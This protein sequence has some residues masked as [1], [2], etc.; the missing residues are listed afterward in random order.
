MEVDTWTVHMV[1]VDLRKQQS[2]APSSNGKGKGAGGPSIAQARQLNKQLA[3]AGQ[4]NPDEISRL[5]REHVTMFNSVNCATALHLL[6]KSTQHDSTVHDLLG[7]RTAVV[8]AREAQDVTPRSLT[9]I[10]WAIG[11][12]RIQD[13][14]LLAATMELASSLMARGRLDAMGL[15]NVAWSLATLHQHATSTSVETVA[16]GEDHASLLDVLAARAGEDPESFKPQELCNLLWAFATLKRRNARL[17]ER[18]TPTTT[19]R[20]GEFTPQGLSQTIWAYSKLNLSK[21]A[22]LLAAASAALPKLGAYDAQSIATLAWSFANLEVEHGPLVTAVCRE[23]KKRPSAFGTASCAQLL[24]ALSRL[25]D[26]VDPAAVG[27]LCSQL[28]SVVADGLNPQNL[29]YALGALAKLPPNLEPE[30]PT[31]LCRAAAAAA[32]R[33][34]GNKLG[35]AA[36]ALSRPSVLDRLAEDAKSSWCSA[37][38]SRTIDVMEHLGWRSIGYVEIAL[39]QLGDFDE[40]SDFTMALTDAASIGI[41]V[42]NERAARRNAVPLELLQRHSAAWAGL[43]KGSTVLVA[44]FDPSPDLDRA[45]K[46]KGL[47]PVHWR[48]FACGADDAAA[49]AWPAHGASGAPFA[50]ACFV[51]WPWYAAGDAASL[52]LRA[53]ASTAMPSAPLWLCGNLDEGAD[54]APDLLGTTYGK[55]ATVETS[56]GATL[57]TA[58][59]SAKVTA[60][61]QKLLSLSGWSSQ[62]KVT[63]PAVGEVGGSAAK[64]SSVQWLT[65]PGLFAGGGVDVMTSALLD[66]LPRPPNGARILDACCGSGTIAAALLAS[67]ARAGGKV[68]VHCLDADAIALEAIKVNVPKAKRLLHC[69]S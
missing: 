34:T 52:L 38:T 48:R 26:G 13:D 49:T 42:A 43:P 6:A 64:A 46:A 47:V 57:C 18:F 53:V 61:D 56:N 2:G 14:K 12:L 24:W 31:L 44:G 10:V 41:E 5:V 69:D 58:K 33:L 51:R 45:L 9:S 28:R 3:A 66:A 29:L 54:A 7:A 62:V 39:R 65:W 36:W 67:S 16:T 8:L 55:A 25:N 19:K 68:K 22:L 23:A 50:A 59:H 40:G 35:I 37:L 15:A 21:H 20:L 63:L 4:S 1:R 32:G 60:A 30:L 17:F 11:K 27:A